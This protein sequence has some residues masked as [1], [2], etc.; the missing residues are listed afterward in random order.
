[1]KEN[2]S[3]LKAYFKDTHQ[4]RQYKIKKDLPSVTQALE[5]WPRL[6]D[7]PELVSTEF[8]RILHLQ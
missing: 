5:D 7:M 6:R 2:Y 1:M 3:T 4:Y 8:P